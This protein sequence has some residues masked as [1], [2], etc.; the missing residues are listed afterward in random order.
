[1]RQAYLVRFPAASSIP[2]KIIPSAIIHSAIT[3]SAVLLA[4]GS[5]SAADEAP[6]PA[7]RTLAGSEVMIKLLSTPI[8]RQEM[9]FTLSQ[10]ETLRSIQT[11]RNE[12]YRNRPPYDP[13]K[14][15]ERNVEVQKYGAES[16]LAIEALLTLAQKARLDEL[17]LQVYFA[18]S[19]YPMNGIG[20]HEYLGFADEQLKQL[21]RIC[22]K[23]VDT[24]CWM[25]NNGD[26]HDY[27]LWQEAR[28]VERLASAKLLAVFTPEQRERLKR[29]EGNPVDMPKLRRQLWS[30]CLDQIRVTGVCQDPKPEG[31][32]RDI[33][34][35]RVMSMRA[36]PPVDGQF[37]R[38]TY[39]LR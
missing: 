17:L 29:M 27:S 22:R 28:Q 1:M 2:S 9:A 19:F 34:T 15:A 16:F 20:I 13:E 18:Y 4:G 36:E 33:A 3:L 35:G 11:H 21:D 39:E 26:R 37:L 12:W 5:T 24:A 23:S 32:P 31:S 8:V 38:A 14:F 30:V 7:L 6:K 10:W 25:F